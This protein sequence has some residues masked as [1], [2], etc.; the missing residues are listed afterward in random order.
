MGEAPNNPS[1]DDRWG[2]FS[3][4]L[5]DR[6][7]VAGKHDFFRNWVRKFIG[8]IKPRKWDQALREDVEQYLDLLVQEGKAGWQNTTPRAGLILSQMRNLLM[9]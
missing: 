1:W 7:V 3:R 4:G 8:F 9:V 2:R 5:L 6:G